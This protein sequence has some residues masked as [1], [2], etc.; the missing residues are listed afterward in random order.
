M[1]GCTCNDCIRSLT[2]YR[3]T[4]TPSAQWPPQ[5]QPF[6]KKSQ[7]YQVCT[8]HTSKQT[9]ADTTFM[10]GAIQRTKTVQPPP[11]PAPARGRGR[12]RGRGGPSR[13]S[14][15]H[16]S[17]RPPKPTFTDYVPNQ[18]PGVTPSSNPSAAPAK[19]VIID[20]VAFQ[21][22]GK[23]LVRKTGELLYRAH[24]P[25]SVVPPKTK[26]RFTDKATSHSPGVLQIQP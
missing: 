3:P 12:G 9:V 25:P 19:E 14:P 18:R 5:I 4:T 11:P 13:P 15:F 20:G 8:I 21:S 6:S 7:G 2:D 10:V 1:A 24:V 26:D 23:T 22:N 16:H 17:Y